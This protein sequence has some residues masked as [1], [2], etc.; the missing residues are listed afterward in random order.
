MSEEYEEGEE[1]TENGIFYYSSRGT[2][3]PFVLETFFDLV[4]GGYILDDT[5]ICYDG[6]NWEEYSTSELHDV[7]QRQ[8]AA[9]K[10]EEEDDYEEENPEEEE[11]SSG[12]SDTTSLTDEG[13][14]A[15]DR[16]AEEGYDMPEGWVEVEADDGQI[17]YYNEI[18]DE[19]TW[20]YPGEFEEEEEEEE[21]GDELVSE[22]EPVPTSVVLP[23][24]RQ[25]QS[26]VPAAPKE[27]VEAAAKLMKAKEYEESSSDDS[28]DSDDS[29]EQRAQMEAE[30]EAFK[31]HAILQKEMEMKKKADE[32][33]AE[34]A[35]IVAEQ[36]ELKRRLEE[37]ANERARLDIIAKEAAELEARLRREEEE[38]VAAEEKRILGEEIAREHAEL[39]RMI[40]EEQVMQDII[41]K[42]KAIA[43]AA[44]E[45]YLKPQFTTK[46]I[47]CEDSDF[48]ENIWTRVAV[49]IPVLR[50]IDGQR[51]MP[52]TL[53]AR[54]I[55]TNQKIIIDTDQLNSFDAAN[56]EVEDIDTRSEASG[57]IGMGFTETGSTTGDNEDGFN[58]EDIEYQRQLDEQNACLLEHCHEPGVLR[59]I[60]KRF[61][62]NEK[63]THIGSGTLIVCSAFNQ[64][65]SQVLP[66]VQAFY[67]LVESSYDTTGVEYNASKE[68]IPFQEHLAFLD[69]HPHP[70]SLAEKAFQ[71]LR[72]MLTPQCIIFTGQAGSGKSSSRTRALEYLLSRNKFLIGESLDDSPTMAALAE[73]NA[74]VESTLSS[75]HKVLQSF[76]HS[77]SYNSIDSSK[78]GLV[79]KLYYEHSGD[80]DKH[81]SDRE[82]PAIVGGHI[83]VL[84]FQKVH[85]TNI[86]DD[87]RN[88]HIFYELLAGKETGLKAYADLRKYAL[89]SPQ[90]YRCLVGETGASNLRLG[91]YD[92]DVLGFSKLI[93][94]LQIVGFSSIEIH[95]MLRIII[96][97]MH[98]TNVFFKD[99]SN[100]KNLDNNSSDIY[101]KVTDMRPLQSAADAFGVEKLA[102][103]D[104]LLTHNTVI[105]KKMH[106]TK[107][108]SKQATFARDQVCLSLYDA[109]LKC[110]TQQINHSIEPPKVDGVLK[111]GGRILA[112]DEE[113]PFICMIDMPG[114]VNNDENSFEQFIINYSNEKLRNVF[115]NSIFTN[116]FCKY[117]YFD[118]DIYSYTQ[119]SAHMLG[120]IQ[121]IHGDESIS[122]SLSIKSAFNSLSPKLQEKF[123]YLRNNT[124]H[125]TVKNE[126]GEIDESKTSIENSTTAIENN[127]KSIEKTSITTNIHISKSKKF[128]V[129][130]ECL[131]LFE[132]PKWG[133]LSVIDQVSNKQDNVNDE[134]IITTLS[135]KREI[136]RNNFYSWAGEVDVAIENG[137]GTVAPDTFFIKHY[138]GRLTY[139]LCFAEYDVPLGPDNRDDEHY[140]ITEDCWATR[141][142]NMHIQ[143][144]V[145]LCLSS[146][147]P[148]IRTIA[149][150]LGNLQDIDH[151]SKKN[152]TAAAL[153]NINA[154]YATVS[155][156]NIATSN[157]Q[158][159][160]ETVSETASELNDDNK[161]IPT[162]AALHKNKQKHTNEQVIIASSPAHKSYKAGVFMKRMNEIS[163]FL[164]TGCTTFHVRCLVANYSMEP[165]EFTRS[166][167]YSQMNSLSIMEHINT[168]SVKETVVI[169]FISFITNIQSHLDS[170]AM[171]YQHMTIDNIIACLLFSTEAPYDS[172]MIDFDNQ[173][174]NIDSK[175]L[176]YI[177]DNL[178]G[179][180]PGSEGEDSLCQ[181]LIDISSVYEQ[182]AS[183]IYKQ[184]IDILQ[185]EKELEFVMSLKDKVMNLCD[186]GTS[187]LREGFKSIGL[188]IGTHAPPPAATHAASI[189]MTNNLPPPI[190]ANANNTESMFTAPIMPSKNPNSIFVANMGLSGGAKGSANDNKAVIE[191]SMKRKEL[192]NKLQPS[193]KL[194]KHCTV[195][196]RNINILI[197]NSKNLYNISKIYGRHC[198]LRAVEHETERLQSLL[199]KVSNF[200][201]TLCKTLLDCIRNL[202]NAEL[203]AE[204][205]G[206]LLKSALE[207][208]KTVG[209][210]LSSDVVFTTNSNDKY[211]SSNSNSTNAQGASSTSNSK[212]GASTS[213][214]TNNTES[215]VK[216]TRSLSIKDLMAA[217]KA[218]AEAKKLS[219]N[220]KNSTLT[221]ITED[222]KDNTEV[223][224]PPNVDLDKLSSNGSSTGFIDPSKHVFSSETSTAQ[225]VMKADKYGGSSSA[226]QEIAS[227]I[228]LTADSLNALNK[229][230]SPTP[231]KKGPGSV[232]GSIAASHVSGSV[233]LSKHPIYK[234]LMNK[235]RSV[236]PPQPAG[237][238]P[239]ATVADANVD[240]VDNKTTNT[241]TISTPT[242]TEAQVQQWV[243]WLSRSIISF[244]NPNT[245][246]EYAN[247]FLIKS[248]YTPGQLANAITEDQGSC[249]FIDAAGYIVDNYTNIKFGHS[250]EIMTALVNNGYFSP[251][252]DIVS[253]TEGIEEDA[254]AE[255]SKFSVPSG[256]DE[257]TVAGP[258]STEIETWMQWFATY[259]PDMNA[260]MHRTYG[261]LLVSPPPS[262]SV[263]P[264][265]D[266]ETLA[267]I[268][269]KSPDYLKVNLNFP[270]DHNDLI[271]L[272][273]TEK[274]YLTSI[275]ISMTE[276]ILSNTSNY[277][278][279]NS[280]NNSNRRVSYAV[281]TARRPSLE[282]KNETTDTS[283]MHT[284]DDNTAIL[285]DTP[286]TKQ[287]KASILGGN[288]MIG[289]T[290]E[291]SSNSRDIFTPL[292]PTSNTTSPMRRTSALGSPMMRRASASINSLSP[293]S[294]GKG[295]TATND[296]ALSDTKNTRKQS[297]MMLAALAN[298]NAEDNG[299]SGMPSSRAKQLLAM[300]DDTTSTNIGYGDDAKPKSAL[301]LSMEDLNEL[302]S[303]NSLKE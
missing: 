294:S 151:Q 166:A 239:T 237:P 181:K 271:L 264:I 277:K 117:H 158:S 120:D 148:E 115:F 66:P 47:W 37:E 83:E 208:Q 162:N 276:N 142:K 290:S 126:E 54:I 288:K 29:S 231:M 5:Q 184:Y 7:Y 223:H 266:P 121:S 144:L 179:H 25:A 32:A 95:G 180:S 269:L 257:L 102:L 246:T 241:T 200:T 107:H 226:D 104:T 156:A 27:V 49:S 23:P 89:G 214:T 240:K 298:N 33:A 112:N 131:L 218:A 109:L 177:L 247:S 103:L 150:S 259:V 153:V 6:T 77:A 227:T 191:L 263:Q 96:G 285:S 135:N 106:V 14:A 207:D 160:S 300:S 234:K 87:S 70:F 152:M 129:N 233:N 50:D 217:K 170:I 221:I 167:V 185:A 118:Y 244:S 175:Y 295:V 17:Y 282:A 173:I 71:Y 139:K 281:S 176:L 82:P 110:L 58:R 2:E 63:Y 293:L 268:I 28:S 146:L 43:A 98:L 252:G 81:F 141:N 51:E 258:I 94:S 289:S 284:K 42:E 15:E 190:S 172:Y 186:T 220:M 20:D 133:I 19:S 243:T 278:I 155:T 18:T 8:V 9:M 90:H 248:I 286:R 132:H 119:N 56:I 38:R 182:T 149:T 41:S 228:L 279:S 249:S 85:V 168:V 116:T 251:K 137:L 145:P 136:T 21:E 74:P 105:G 31:K 39:R 24:P 45:A 280:G 16:D 154:K 26:S 72:I 301:L 238:S 113:R 178:K 59:L 147:V 169:P 91:N 1:G 65:E 224:T 193:K 283:D 192:T 219:K 196:Y 273:L 159:F 44:L 242:Y 255:E 127:D 292:S 275:P 123:H 265:Y 34:A 124:N 287:R 250:K 61:Q 93:E 12:D 253:V 30:A 197:E 11:E 48:P 260:N 164:Q 303:Y 299:A 232:T 262:S 62:A 174:V 64:I 4:D 99:Q 53:E 130:D 13:E 229:A 270:I 138:E 296:S 215:T 75:A 245:I 92:S 235:R 76:G 209:I 134:S 198:W 274:G 60:E 78:F 254:D 302:P 108:T 225:L 202:G 40:T 73:L 183:L 97:I 86:D 36:V 101:A 84:L 211:T 125:K 206:Y 171:H 161:N 46:H 236:A 165:L 261:T 267:R 140:V 22:Q 10:G 52:T 55:G 201:T 297:I 68:T 212:G 222:P 213:K 189:N 128:P 67:G 195:D 203:I 57:G 230:N 111:P 3:G 205:A 187:I 143:H 210:V 100:N 199:S 216:K 79:S 157:D 188:G 69:A 272:A 80:I 114:F 163:T 122:P 204:E 256:L 194:L 291:T 35:R 88:F